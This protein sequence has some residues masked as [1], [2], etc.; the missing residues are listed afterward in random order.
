MRSIKLFLSLTFISAILIFLSAP[1]LAEEIMSKA[2]LPVLT[3]SAGQSTDVTTLNIIMEEAEILYDYCDTP[4]LDLLAEGVGLGGR[5]SGEGFHAVVYTDLDTYPKGTPYKT[6]IF[7]IGASLKGMG[8]SGLTIDS[9]VARL[10]SLIDYCKKN[11]IFIIAI[12]AGGASKRGPTGSDNEKM[13]DAVAPFVDYLIVVEDSNKDGRFTKISE[14][15]GIP[16][17]QVDYA[18]DIV[19]IL[20]QVFQ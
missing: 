6:I 5:E 11:N 10:T 8:A 20:Q 3:T 19:S 17:S 15:N 4:G 2:Q 7:A 12:H 9:E 14:E 16:I 18:L 13:I 1:G